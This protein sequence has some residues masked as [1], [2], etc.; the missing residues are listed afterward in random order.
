MHWM[1]EQAIDK[2]V[3]WQLPGADLMN[4]CE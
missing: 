1:I 2:L 3:D 4:G